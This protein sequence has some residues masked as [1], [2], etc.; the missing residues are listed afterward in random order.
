[1]D[2][3]ER[4]DYEL[5]LPINYDHYRFQR[6]SGFNVKSTIILIVCT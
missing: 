1:M 3:S 2:V 4:Y 5:I 6:L